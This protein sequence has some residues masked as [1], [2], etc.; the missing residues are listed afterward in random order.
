MFF[1][2][3]GVPCQEGKLTGSVFAVSSEI[4]DLSPLAFCFEA[5]AYPGV[6]FLVLAAVSG[7][8]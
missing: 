1:T 5:T 8:S 3:A 7:R 6:C 2:A 4:Q